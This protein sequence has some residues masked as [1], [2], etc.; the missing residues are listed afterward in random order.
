M[1]LAKIGLIPAEQSRKT[2]MLEIWSFFTISLFL[3][4]SRQYPIYGISFD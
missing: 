2:Y 4:A 1:E 3:N